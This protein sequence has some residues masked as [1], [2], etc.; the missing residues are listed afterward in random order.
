MKQPIAML[1]ALVAD[2]EAMQL[3]SSKDKFGDFKDGFHTTG[4]G[5]IIAWPNLAILLAE[6]KEVLGSY[7]QDN[8][9]E[10]AAGVEAMYEPAPLEENLMP[11]EADTYATIQVETV[12]IVWEVMLDDNLTENE[13]K[14]PAFNDYWGNSGIYAMRHEAMK[15]GRWVDQV[16]KAADGDDERFDGYA[17]DF[18]VCPVLVHMVDWTDQG[19]VLPDVADAVAQL[20][21]EFP[22]FDANHQQA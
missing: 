5:F 21:R 7:P 8:A 4:E 10:F 3:P 2:I 13:H 17:F 16:W 20:K 22:P 9:A 6:A 1:R 14:F 11:R 19:P 18:E 15:I 12:L